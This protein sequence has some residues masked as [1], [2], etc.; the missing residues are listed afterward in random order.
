MSPK[1][2]L[3]LAERPVVQPSRGLPR[4]EHPRIDVHPLHGNGAGPV[5]RPSPRQRG[6][7]GRHTPA[8]E[9][10]LRGAPLTAGRAWP[11]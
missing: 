7:V 4:L 9:G 8:C 3:A 1:Y 5:Q 11:G 6:V 10:I 2:T